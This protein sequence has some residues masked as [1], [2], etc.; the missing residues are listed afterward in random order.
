MLL[1]TLTCRIIEWLDPIDNNNALI[2]REL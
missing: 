1:D 2:V